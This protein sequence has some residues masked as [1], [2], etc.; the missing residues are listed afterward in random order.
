MA[1]V[2]D[3]VAF[4][5]DLHAAVSLAASADTLLG[6]STQELSLDTQIANR[7]F[8][9]P[10]SGGDAAPT[11]RAMVA[12]DLGTGLTP[13]FAG[14]NLT[15]NI[16]FSSLDRMISG[17][18]VGQTAWATGTIGSLNM[19]GMQFNRLGGGSSRYTLSS[20]NVS[21]NLDNLFDGGVD[22]PVTIAQGATGV[23]TVNFNPYIGWTADTN[24]GYTYSDG[25]IVINFYYTSL[26]SNILIEF[27]RPVAGV[28]TW[29]TAATISGNT[30]NPLVIPLPQVNFV[31]QIRFSFS[32]AGT[33]V[34]PTEIEYFCSRQQSAGEAVNIPQ[35]CGFAVD[36]ANSVLNIRDTSWTVRTKFEPKV[37]TGSSAVAYLFD[38]ENN[39]TTAGAKLVSFRNQGSEKAFIDKDGYL[40]IPRITPTGGELVVAG[41]IQLPSISDRIT[42]GASEFY[43]YG[44]GG[45]DLNLVSAHL[46]CE[47]GVWVYGGIYG[48][49]KYGINCGA[50]ATRL[51]LFAA[52]TEFVSILSG[53]NVGIGTIA[54]TKNLEVAQSVS[55]TPGILVSRAGQTIGIGIEA[56]GANYGGGIW[57]NDVMQASFYDTGMALGSYASQNPPTGGLILS[58]SLGIGTPTF[59]TSAAKVLGIGNGTAPSTA[60]A[61]MVQLWSADYAAGDARLHL[62]SETGVTLILGNGSIRGCNTFVGTGAV[63]ISAGGSDQ[64][65]GL[66][67]SGAGYVALNG[68]VSVSSLSEDLPVFTDS[69][70][71]L[72]SKSVADTRTALGLGVADSPTFA[73]L[74]VGSLAGFVKATAGVLSAAAL[75]DAD[76]PDTIT[77][78]NITQITNR[79]HTNLSDIGSLS[80]GTIDGYLDQAV[81]Q[82]SSP[83]FNSLS[84]TGG[85]VTFPATQ[86]ASAGANVLDDYEE[87]TWTPSLKFG[88]AS[89]GMTYTTQEGHYTKIGNIVIIT[90]YFLLSAKGSSVGSA[91]IT[92]LP[93]TA[94]SASVYPPVSLSMSAVTAPLG[95]ERQA[96]VV[97]NTTEMYL[98][99]IGEGGDVYQLTNANFANTSYIMV[100]CAYR[101]A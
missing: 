73:G 1:L 17:A 11:F 77:L 61:D 97:P 27:Y 55:N 13:T 71:V 34:W 25:L 84:I 6:I 92:G 22:A 15:G 67:P 76:I 98:Q 16:K 69:A 54:P 39:L 23:I 31:K 8:A 24:N 37:A 48:N 47:W 38:T 65:V 14:L 63:A 10:V 94:N 85:Q 29:T 96:Y 78:T 28:D 83:T 53:G 64:N 62:Q 5:K 52:G 20:S 91:T 68:P 87:G 59:G 57:F 50:G 79:S 32:N 33:A 70:K 93:F 89:V 41:N 36:V 49:R 66:T 44:T 72:V 2:W 100:G 80:H 3:K 74:T 12:A 45:N 58:G 60:P 56:F 101:V 46:N 26:A 30:K 43:L 18:Y 19:V 88:G 95:Y 40:T 4:T 90:G 7:I 9:G 21:G 51:S 99:R 86:N 35:Y 81:K 75:T 42:W 82:A